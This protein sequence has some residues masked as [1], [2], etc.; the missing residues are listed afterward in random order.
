M[1]NVVIEN[2]HDDLGGDDYHH[3][4]YLDGYRGRRRIVRRDA[5]GRHHRH[6]W[7]EWFVYHCNNTGCTGTALVRIGWIVSLMD[8]EAKP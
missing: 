8:A 3:W 2:P 6:A 1:K 4:V 7:R 5:N